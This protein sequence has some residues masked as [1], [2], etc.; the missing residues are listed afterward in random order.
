MPIRFN[1]N[2]EIR[3]Y[4]SPIQRYSPFLCINQSKS[5][6]VSRTKLRKP[7]IGSFVFL[8]SFSMLLRTPSAPQLLHSPQQT[9]HHRPTLSSNS[10]L[11]NS[12][13]STSFDSGLSSTTD[14]TPPLHKRATYS[15]YQ[16]PP[17]QYVQHPI[18][19]GIVWKKRKYTKWKQR[20]F[21]LFESR[22]LIYYLDRNTFQSNGKPFGYVDLGDITNI[23][24]C[25][26]SRD[27]TDGL[28]FFEL[29]TPKRTY[30]LGHDNRQSATEW[31]QV[32]LPLIFGK[33]VC[34]GWLIKSGAN[35][36]S[37][38]WKKRWFVLSTFHELRYYKENEPAPSQGMGTIKL[39]EAIKIGGGSNLVMDSEYRY[40]IEIVTTDRVWVLAG[41]NESSIRIWRLKLIEA[42]NACQS[43][44]VHTVPA[45][46]VH[47]TKQVMFYIV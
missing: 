46:P 26:Q 4:Q 41:N 43:Q 13:S 21:A 32:L 40:V 17:I 29:E 38:G 9:F 3:S 7:R 14:Q 24:H 16:T 30:I 15:H 12:A 45:L 28:F 19:S 23:S 34:N 33:T 31:I 11:T 22:K 44:M 27:R 42:M 2:R 39:K 36:V 25:S 6:R 47:A 37:R 18:Y 8:F 1:T 20:W 35:M 10:A 5:K